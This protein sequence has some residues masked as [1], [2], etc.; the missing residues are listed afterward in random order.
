MLRA[1]EWVSKQQQNNI[2]ADAGKMDWVFTGSFVR[3]GHFLPQRT[4]SIVAIYHDPAAMMDNATAGG[5]SDELWFAKE[6]AVL[7]VGAPVTVIIRSV[8]KEGVPK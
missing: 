3:D 5:E 1:E 2:L 8:H 4:G 7:P 6:G